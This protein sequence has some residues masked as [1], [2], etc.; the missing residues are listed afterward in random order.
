M[1]KLLRKTV[2]AAVAALLISQ[3]AS[4]ISLS[5]SGSNS[6]TIHPYRLQADDYN[7]AKGNTATGSTED[8]DTYIQNSSYGSEVTMNFDVT[9]VDENGTATGQKHTI[10]NNTGLTGLADGYYL[11]D[12]LDDSTDSAFGASDAFIIQLP[13]AKSGGGVNRDVHIYPKLLNNE[14][15]DSGAD[16][17]PDTPGNDDK[18][19]VTLTK[20]NADRTTRLPGVTFKVYYKNAAGKWE[21]AKESNGSDKVYTTKSDTGAEGTI[22][23][24]GL[25]VGDY[26]FVEQAALPGY[27]LDQKPIPFTINGTAAATSVEATND[28]KLTVKDEVAND[29]SG[30]TSYN[31]IITADVP[32]KPENLASYVIKGSFEGLD[33][34]DMIV[35]IAG[36]TEGTDYEVTIGKDDNQKDIFT[37]EIKDLTK[38]KADTPLVIKMESRLDNSQSSPSNSA[39]I[40]YEYVY[41]P[42]A[43]DPE[44][45]DIPDPGDQNYNHQTETDAP[46]TP[47]GL[48]LKTFTV[49]NVGSDDQTAELGGSTYIITGAV[50]TPAF[51]ATLT[52]RADNDT[53]NPGKSEIVNYAPGKYTVAQ[54]AVKNGYILNDT[55]KTI[56][57]TADGKMYEDTNGDGK[58]NASPNDDTDISTSGLVF[59]NQK[60]NDNFALPF[61][62][63]TATRVFTVTGI[64]VM[65]AAGGFI[66]MV[67]RKKDEDEEDNKG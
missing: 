63:T 7:T 60:T 57:I 56:F 58:L 13:V 45:P 1:K 4:M 21:S 46:S 31:W 22:T 27:L 15:G 30:N 67:L 20:F 24:T 48:T 32:S 62:G 17:T 49:S 59:I 29:A 10:A 3:S 18:H 26:Y 50:A 5:A 23:I 11:I 66:F 42:G 19:Y 25:P 6:L 28:A 8:Y 34:S 54:T 9:P 65:L 2:S 12:P 33:P 37:I 43:G 47:A 61:T 64:C 38:L 51:T 16:S 44:I 39:S 55:V 36:M 41:N 35:S 40:E 52:D 14:D 53:Q